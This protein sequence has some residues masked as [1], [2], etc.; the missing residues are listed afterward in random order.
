MK[1]LS[2]ITNFEGDHIGVPTTT[3]S[4]LDKL[5]AAV[6]Y[7]KVEA[8]SVTGGDP[9]FEYDKHQKYFRRLLRACREMDIPLELHTATIESEFPYGKCMRVIYHLRSVDQLESIVRHG[10]EGVRVVFT[11]DKSWTLDLIDKIANFCLK[12]DA[13]DELYFRRV[14]DRGHC[15]GRHCE[16]YLRAGDG[17]KW[18]YVDH[19]K[20]NPPYFI[21]GTIH[22]QFADISM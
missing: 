1:Y 12:S 13:I 14:S 7:E 22:Y 8:I 2:I 17:T 18:T 4:S 3:I 5:K 6:E 10:H 11:V 15:V 21:N 9:L 16:E 20:E 19:F